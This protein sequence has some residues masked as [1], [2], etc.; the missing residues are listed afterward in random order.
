MNQNKKNSLPLSRRGIITALGFGAAALM[1]MAAGLLIPVYGEAIRI[2]PRELFVTLGSALTG[3]IGGIIIGFMAHSWFAGEDWYFRIVSITIH[4]LG[5]LWM[6]ISYKKLVHEKLKMPWLLLGWIGLV[7]VYY[8]VTLFFFFVAVSHT[9]FPLLFEQLFGEL[10]LGQAY[11]GLTTAAAPEFIA[12][13]IITTLIII[14]LPPKY[15]R[16]LW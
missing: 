12:T 7:F 9:F 1:V 8:F 6:G 2:D 5:G 14:V 10:S 13:A 4:V 15:R 3:P 16:P 11:I